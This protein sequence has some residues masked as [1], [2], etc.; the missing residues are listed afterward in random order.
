MNLLKAIESRKSIRVY[1]TKAVEEEKIEAIVKAGN[2]APIFGQI[3][4]TVIENPSLLK[5]VNDITLNMMKNSGNDFLIKRASTPGYNP[6]Y[7]APVMIV[8]SA[9]N[10]ND[11]NG[12][13]MANVSCSAEN[14]LIAATDFDLGSCFVMGPIMAFSSPDLL[15]KIDMPENYVPLCGVLLGYSSDDSFAHEREEKNN[16]T[17]CR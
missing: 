8:L 1:D 11:N 2:I 13:N 4:I 3:H 6:L 9:P 10:R 17:Y 5:E 15:K 16:V 7:G 12:F 14:M